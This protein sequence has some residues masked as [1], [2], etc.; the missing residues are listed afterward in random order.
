MILIAI[1]YHSRGGGV[2]VSTQEEGTVFFA[3]HLDIISKNS[4]E[5]S[6]Q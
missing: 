6:F 5:A 3:N 2:A 1:S 4:H